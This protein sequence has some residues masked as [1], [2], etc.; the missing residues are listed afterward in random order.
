MRSLLP[1]EEGET[2]G[3]NPT[4]THFVE[5]S[6]DKTLKF[7]KLADIQENGIC[8]DIYGYG[9]GKPAPS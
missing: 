6:R 8:G 9:P 7:A 2:Y 4:N 3:S 5:A 1:L